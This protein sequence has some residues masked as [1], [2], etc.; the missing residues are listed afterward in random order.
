M[1]MKASAAAGHPIDITPAELAR[2]LSPAHFVEVRQTPGGP[3]A[4]ETRQ[5]IEAS[6]KHLDADRAALQVR[7]DRLEAA[8]RGLQSSLDSL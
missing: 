2:V 3:A 8:A 1:A 7:R 5:A 4:T 6:R